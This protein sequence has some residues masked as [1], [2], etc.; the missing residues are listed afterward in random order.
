MQERVVI[1]P[2]SIVS[3]V[4]ICVDKHSHVKYTYPIHFQFYLCVPD[5]LQDFQTH[6][7]NLFTPFVKTAIKLSQIN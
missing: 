4:K 1:I 5:I 3:T 6:F 7:T 2:I